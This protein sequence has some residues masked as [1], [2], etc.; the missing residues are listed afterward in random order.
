MVQLEHRHPAIFEA[1]K[2]GHFVLHKTGK[3]S[4]AIA[5]DHGHEQNNHY[6]MGD[7]GVIELI[8]NDQDLRK[9]M[10]SGPEM[11]CL[12]LEFQNTFF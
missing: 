4:S 1:F 12:I 8:Q 2:Y 6:M 10:L 7:W 3:L 11:L 9:W 5:L